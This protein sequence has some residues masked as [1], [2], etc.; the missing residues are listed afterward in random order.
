MKINFPT[1]LMPKINYL[2]K[3]NLTAPPPPPNQKV[4]PLHCVPKAAKYITDKLSVAH[5]AL[6]VAPFTTSQKKNGSDCTICIHFSKIFLGEAPT[7]PPARRDI[8]LRAPA[9]S[10]CCALR[11]FDDATG[12]GPSGSDTVQIHEL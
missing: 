3:Q 8:P 10:P 11:Q 4:V 1:E 9:P 5:C 6:R 2:S 12:S 7:P